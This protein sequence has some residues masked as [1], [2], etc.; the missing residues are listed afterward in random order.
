MKKSPQ[1]RISTSLP[2][3]QW[4]FI[5][6]SFFWRPKHAV[7]LTVSPICIGCW[8]EIVDKY[9]S[10]S[11][12]FGRTKFDELWIDTLNPTLIGCVT[13]S[14]RCWRRSIWS[15]STCWRNKSIPI[16]SF[17]IWADIWMTHWITFERCLW[18]VEEHQSKLTSARGLLRPHILRAVLISILTLPF[19]STWA[20]IA[21]FAFGIIQC[22]VV[23]AT[24]HC[25]VSPFKLKM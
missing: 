1:F 16:G 18:T 23:I 9:T 21:G 24:S 2:Y 4:N 20:Y 11:K 8:P 17:P 3:R 12:F 25:Y 10:D 13:T 22:L 19:E 7:A 15:F 14:H 5:Q 6:L